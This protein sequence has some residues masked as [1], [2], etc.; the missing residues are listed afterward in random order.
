MRLPDT[1]GARFVAAMESYWQPDLKRDVL[2]PVA[3]PRLPAFAQIAPYMRRIDE[4]GW[5]SN[6]GP[7]V[8]EFERRLAVHGGGGAARVATVANGTIGIALALLAY[9]VPAGTLCMV[10]AWTFAATAHAVRL[11]GLVPWIVDVNAASWA[12]EAPARARIAARRPRPS[13]G[14][15]SR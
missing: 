10:P 5:Y 9:E 2:I 14:G 1:H 11:A 6:G 4:S 7:L 13:G 15:Y 8:Q 12:L 3:K